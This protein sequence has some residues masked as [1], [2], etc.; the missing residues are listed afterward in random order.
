MMTISHLHKK[1]EW[2]TRISHSSLLGKITREEN[3]GNMGAINWLTYQYI[4]LFS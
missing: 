4:A 1:S 3:A 2:G